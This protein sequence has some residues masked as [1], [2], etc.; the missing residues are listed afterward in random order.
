MDIRPVVLIAGGY[1]VFGGRL[2]RLLAARG[3][4]RV[5]VAGR[6]L[7]SARAFCEAL[8]GKA[9]PLLFDRDA[10]PMPTLRALRPWCVVDAA[11][12]FQAY[13]EEVD[14][15]RLAHAALACGAHYLD[16]S[17]DADFT[18]GITQLDEAAHMAQRVAI[19]G[20]STVPAISA[21][22]VRTLREGLARID[23]IESVVLPG[24]RA[25]RGLSVMRAILAQVGRPLRLWR[26]GDWTEVPGWSG[27][28]RDG[29]EL[30]DG[31]RVASRWSSYIGSPDLRLF[32]AAFGARSVL[33][34]A[35]LELSLLHWS[36]WLLGWLPRL[37][38]VRSLEP[39][40]RALRWIADRFERFGSDRGG[41]RVDVIGRD[42]D[43][44]ARRHT[45]TLIAERGDG[46]YVPALPSACLIDRLL[47]G[48]L[49]PGARACLDDLQLGDIEAASVVLPI[50][51]GRQAAS[52]ETL[53]ERVMGRAEWS[54]MPEPVRD[55][56]DLFDQ[57]V[58]VGEAR[59]SAGGNALAWIV[60]RV[61][62]FPP[63]IECTPVRVTM[64]RN[65]DGSETWTRAFGR[66]RF[67]STLSRRD[68]DPPGR[69]RERF[70]PMS[71]R[72]ALPADESGLRMPLERGQWLGIP[73]PGWLTPRSDTREFVDAQGRFC[74]DVDISLPL[75][76]RVVRYEGW[77]QPDAAAALPA[78][79][80]LG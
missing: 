74:F 8:G 71:F 35:G 19:S 1:G 50:R 40:A 76:G 79:T 15:Y 51:C 67:G 43:G 38:V 10:D 64:Q 16:L 29:L 9:E 2:A 68:S 54:R 49:A 7:A 57:R 70:G 69:I 42:N 48:E 28:R 66:H 17:D 25:P 18:A 78:I 63:A 6:S 56:H 5:V 75:L 37:R 61:M 30:R 62:R 21:A 80:M 65:H 47:R 73:L 4:L 11:G 46:P 53:Y 39:W 22:A 3:D 77:L 34:R 31:T 13:G 60:A 41:M 14:P 27:L 20:A 33:F 36:L 26:G 58:F 52:A 72:L 24:N 12:P 32:P 55:A 23:V 59:I 44:H 45:W